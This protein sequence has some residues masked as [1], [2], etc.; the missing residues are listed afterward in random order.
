MSKFQGKVAVVTGGSSGI[1]L[2]TASLLQSEGGHVVVTGRDTKVLDQAKAALGS[3]ALALQSDTSK[4][5]D[6]EALVATVKAK[7]DRVDLLFI[8]AGIAHFAPLESVDEAFWDNTMNTNI[9]GA[10]FTVQKFLP[11]LKPGSSIVL[12]T[13][14]VDQKGMATTSVYSA[15][16][17]A[18]RSLARTLAGELVERGIRVNAIAPGPITTPIYGKLGLPPEHVDVFAAQMREANPMKRFGTSD[19]VA[20][21]ALYLAVDATYTTGAEL[22]VDGGV[23]QL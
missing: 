22:V 1:G 21:A 20:K 8:N 7:H 17:A 11:L 3:K 16:K 13:S 2:A 19:E 6:I 5:A 18:L 12:T 9:K 23:T 4:I 10:F 15:S 14:I